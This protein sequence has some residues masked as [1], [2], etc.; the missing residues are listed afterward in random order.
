MPEFRISSGASSYRVRCF[1]SISPLHRHRATIRCTV[2]DS[3]L[4]FHLASRVQDNR[5]SCARIHIVFGTISWFCLQTIWTQS[6]FSRWVDHITRWI[7]LHVSPQEGHNTDVARNSSSHLSRSRAADIMFKKCLLNLCCSIYMM[8][9]RH[10]RV[11]SNGSR[12]EGLTRRECVDAYASD[13]KNIG[14]L[15]KRQYHFRDICNL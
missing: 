12:K 9:A 13:S 1:S 10:Y 15:R 5:A 4:C 11:V 3:R 14:S 2:R 6:P 7:V 8:A